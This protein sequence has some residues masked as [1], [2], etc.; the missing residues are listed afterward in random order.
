MCVYWGSI[1]LQHSDFLFLPSRC[2]FVCPVYFECL[3]C[4]GGNE[5][6]FEL[7]F[8]LSL[9]FEDVVGSIL[10][11][12][13]SHHSQNASLG[14]ILQVHWKTQLQVITK[15]IAKT[16]DLHEKLSFFELLSQ[17]KHLL[18]GGLE[19]SLC[20]CHVTLFVLC[21]DPIFEKSKG[22]PKKCGISKQIIRTFL[23]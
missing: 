7:G 14:G 10:Y 23:K 12:H 15:S 18:K 17:T 3:L 4:S 22:G 9:T 5:N 19:Q 2:L 6:I 11:V 16:Q 13:S 8:Y 20:L 21:R 1:L